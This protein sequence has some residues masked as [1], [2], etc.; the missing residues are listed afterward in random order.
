MTRVSFPS[1]RP[2]AAPEASG[3]RD[4]GMT[5]LSRSGQGARGH[6]PYLH[7]LEQSDGLFAAVASGLLHPL[8]RAL[9]QVAELCG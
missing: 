1:P 3:L 4:E 2:L 7:A 6:G 8:S 5:G 9:A